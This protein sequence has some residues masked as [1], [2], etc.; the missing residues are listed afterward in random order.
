MALM[1][2]RTPVIVQA[3]LLA[4]LSVAV[5]LANPSAAVSYLLAVLFQA[6]GSYQLAA[7]LAFLQAVALAHLSV[8]ASALPAQALLMAVLFPVPLSQS[9]HHARVFSV[10]LSVSVQFKLHHA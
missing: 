2:A 9:Q 6:A 5:L 8:A 3:D 7:D 1:A 10:T 4:P